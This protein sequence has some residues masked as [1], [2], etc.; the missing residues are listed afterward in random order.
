[1]DTIVDMYI[2]ID[3]PTFER[4]SLFPCCENHV[5]KGATIKGENMLPIG[6][7]F[8]PSIVDPIRIE[9]NFKGHSIYKLQKLNYVKVNEGAQWLIGRVLDLR[10]RE[11]GL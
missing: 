4:L 3:I 6:S 1:M 8:F 7:I 9:N 2:Y 5:L 11:R 10:P